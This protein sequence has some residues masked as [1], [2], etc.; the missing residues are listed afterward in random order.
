MAW[1]GPRTANDPLL[2]NHHWRVTVRNHWKRLRLPC[3]RCHRPIAY[4][5][6][7]YLGGRRRVNPR[8]L[9]VGHIVDRY[10]AKR[11]GWT[12]E[13][14]NALTN[15]QPECVDCSNK[16]GARLG[17]K[18]QRARQAQQQPPTNTSRRW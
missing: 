10:A 18:V 4:D 1:R 5:A 9:V 2:T 12:D 16:S 6:P 7:R 3:A 15:T 8:A 14:I 17:Q 13:Q 11:M